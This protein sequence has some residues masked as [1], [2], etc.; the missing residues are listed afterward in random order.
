MRLEVSDLDKQVSREIKQ[1][2]LDDGITEY[3]VNCDYCD[4]SGKIET[5]NNGPIGDCPV[6]EGNGEYLLAV[7]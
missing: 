7:N 2:L 6:C 1:G 3:P 4:A 5:D